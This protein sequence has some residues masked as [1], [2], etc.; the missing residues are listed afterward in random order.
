MKGQQYFSGWD[1][2][3]VGRCF[4]NELSAGLVC[5]IL[6]FYRREDG[7]GGVWLGRLWCISAGT[8]AQRE[9]RWVGRGE[10]S[11]LYAWGVLETCVNAVEG[12]KGRGWYTSIVGVS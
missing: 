7:A 1:E 9:R 5:E 3:G 11:E 2:E 12:R 10:E 4:G 6:S 8:I